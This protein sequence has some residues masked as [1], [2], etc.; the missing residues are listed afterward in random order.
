MTEKKDFTDNQSVTYGASPDEDYLDHTTPADPVESLFRGVILQHIQD[1]KNKARRPCEKMWK[2]EA[3]YWLFHD[4][5]GFS[6]V[7][8]LAGWSPE[9][10]RER[11]KE[12]ATRDFTPQRKST[13]T[14][15]GVK[16]Y[17]RPQRPKKR[18]R[19]TD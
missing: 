19:F 16:V 7:C 1:F 13:R 18:T 8:E 12:A 4:Q 3:E 9:W 5:R 15:K 14:A 11:I 17:A 6:E 2:R 10:V